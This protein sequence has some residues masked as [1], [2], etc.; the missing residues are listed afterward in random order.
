VRI[1]GHRIR[2]FDP[3]QQRAQVVGEHRGPAVGGVDVEPQSFVGAGLREF[4]QGVDRAGGHRARGGHHGDRVDAVLAVARDLCAEL[5]HPHPIAVVDRDVPDVRGTQAQGVGRAVAH[6]VRLGGQVEPEGRAR[7]DA[8]A[9]H[10]P[11]GAVI[12]SYLQA[13]HGRH[14]AAGGEFTAR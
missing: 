6:H 8:L 7:G 14:R 11:A 5:V 13:D 10:V 9:A 12:A 2:A 1:E 4:V 3:G